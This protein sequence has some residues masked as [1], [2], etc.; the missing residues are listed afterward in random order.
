MSQP[1]VKT[2]PR[3]RVL[4]SADQIRERVREM[5]LQ[6]AKD[7]EGKYP[8]FVGVLKGACMFQ[9]DIARATPIDLELDFLAV[10]SYGAGTVSSGNVELIMDLRTDIRGRHVVLCEGVVDSGRSVKFILDLLESRGAASIQV[11]TLLDKAP[12]RKIPVPVDYKGWTIG[13]VFVSGY[14]MDSAVRFRNL[15]YVGVLEEA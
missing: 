8:L 4:F 3:I 7:L 13:D 6:L 1:T 14:G 10:S 15:P 12:C 2:E 5:G 11:A 9:M